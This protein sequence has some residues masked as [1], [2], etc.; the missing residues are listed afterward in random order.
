MKRDKVLHLITG[1][2]LGWTGL[3][4]T[5][6]PI[7][8]SVIAGLFWG[9]GREA[10]NKWGLFFQK[11]TGW[12]WL[13]IAYTVAGSLVMGVLLK[14]TNLAEKIRTAETIAEIFS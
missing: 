6:E 11:R 3:I 13:D 5:S 10:V 4:V 1:F 7:L 9:C 2:L 12:D 14:V 8:A